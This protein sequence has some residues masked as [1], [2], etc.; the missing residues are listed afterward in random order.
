[1]S[2]ST[3]GFSILA[4]IGLITVLYGFYYNNKIDRIAAWPRAD[5]QIL[6]KSYETNS[7]L[8]TT[9][10]MFKVTYSYTVNGVKYQSAGICYGSNGPY[11]RCNVQSLINA[12]NGSIVKI[13]Y[14]PLMPSESYIM[15]GTKTYVTIFWGF[16][17]ILIA[18]YFL[19]SHYYSGAGATETNTSPKGKGTG[20][21]EVLG[22]SITDKKFSG[23]RYFW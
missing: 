22:G 17:F 19:Y 13:Y 23:A 11:L 14:N 2:L 10:I 16:V 8:D 5:G 12:Q 21:A 1:M 7:M 6:T 3:I 20:R 15:N 9:T 18:A 4:I